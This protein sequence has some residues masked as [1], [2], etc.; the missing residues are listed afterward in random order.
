MPR[1]FFPFLLAQNLIIFLRIQMPFSS[2]NKIVGEFTGFYLFEMFS[3]ECYFTA[4]KHCQNNWKR[5]FISQLSNTVKI[6][7]KNVHFH[8]IGLGLGFYS[9]GIYWNLGFYSRAV[10]F[11]IK[12]GLPHELC[13]LLLNSDFLMSCVF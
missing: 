13:I 10:Y 6:I 1:L 3:K 8:L 12:L 2:V 9:R 5:M 7:E 11:I 4:F